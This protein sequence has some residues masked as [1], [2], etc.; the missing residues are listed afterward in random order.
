MAFQSL[1][2]VP[3]EDVVKPTKV[4]KNGT[5]SK[6]RKGTLDPEKRGCKFC[7]LNKVPGIQKIKGEITGKSILVIAQSPGPKE[8]DE[9]KEL[10]GPAGEFL[11]TEL[12]RVGL[13]RKDV[14][15]QNVVRCYPADWSEG[16]YTSYLKMRNPT[17]EEIHCCS[18]YTEEALSKSP[19]KQI[20]ILGQIAAKQFLKV[21]SL[22]AQKTFWSEELNARIYLIDH[23][24]FF[25]RGYGKG[26]RM[27]AFRQTLQRL[28]N[29]AQGIENTDK[30]LSDQF[31]YV[32]EQ[33][34]RLVTTAKQ[35]YN[36]DRI[37]RKYAAKGIRVTVDIEDDEFNDEE[38]VCKDCGTVGTSYHREYS[39]DCPC[40]GEWVFKPGR[41][42]I[43]VGIC[44]RPGLSFFFVLKHPELEGTG[45][46]SA[47]HNLGAVRTV[48][49]ELLQDKDVDKA[50][51]YG[52]TD[53][54]KLLEVEGIIVK[55]F[56][57]DTNLSE[58]LRFSDKKQYGLDIIGEQRF[59][60]FSGWKLLVVP[61]M[62]KAYGDQLIKEGATKLPA[63][64]NGAL[65]AQAKFLSNKKQYHL[66]YCSLE[67][68]RLYNGGDCDVTKRIERSNKKHIPQALMDLYIDLSFVLQSMEP[69]GPLFDFDQHDKLAIIYPVLTKK[70]KRELRK[71]I[72]N[73]EF[74]PGSPQQ[75]YK[76]IYS[77]LG[78]EY[79][80]DGKPD[81]RKMTLLMLGREHEF[82][83]KL[84]EW[85][86]N[87]KV[88]GILAGYHRCA[89]AW[90]GR[91]RTKWWSTGSRTGRLSSGAEK[92]KKESTIIN[93]QNI[94][95]DAQIRNLRLEDF[96]EQ[97]Y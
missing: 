49:T 11:W 24:A 69:K 78:L 8:N 94:K 70:L 25:I 38:W 47:L 9:G 29:D 18:I 97:I 83:K 4:K 64:F 13:R 33:D 27:D 14:D 84:L 81:T 71:L 90:G 6:P 77:D 3:V 89:T 10:L 50:M 39:K 21:R 68:L 80:F 87:S 56:T 66:K 23:P 57:H 42:V 40:G 93:L 91:L 55:S 28:A 36:A 17:K 46:P 74:N 44:P 45:I 15:I 79:P 73:K 72:G 54:T 76:A 65:D 22:P 41:R 82:P 1:F 7:P 63:V 19:A 16:S 61:E 95:R 62:M 59:P 88:E 34:Y 2:D 75:C 92:N 32:R 26:P 12:K 60:E 96:H 58:Y 85:R 30:N 53:T 31:A 52:C 37:I 51:H 20:L 43:G 67:T 86:T 5:P 48:V 35:A